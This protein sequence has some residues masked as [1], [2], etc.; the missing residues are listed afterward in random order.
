M[1]HLGLPATIKTPLP[2]ERLD[3]LKTIWQR[4]SEAERKAYGFEFTNFIVKCEGK[5]AI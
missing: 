2:I 4:M 1:Y 5:N 3:K